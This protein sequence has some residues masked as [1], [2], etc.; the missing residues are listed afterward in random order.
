MSDITKGVEFSNNQQV[1]ATRL[2]NL[3]DGATINTG[4]VTTDKIADGSVTTSKI[5]DDAVT[6]AKIQNDAVT[7]DKIADGSITRDKLAENAMGVKSIQKGVVTINDTSS[8]TVSINTIN[9][10]K[11]F[12]ILDGTAGINTTNVSGQF[13]GYLLSLTSNQLTIG[14]PEPEASGNLQSKFSWQVV[15]FY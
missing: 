10:D 2:N 11:A 1:T 8:V 12:V 7:T 13:D 9:P 5:P 14:L 4:A 15:E 6:S 3:V